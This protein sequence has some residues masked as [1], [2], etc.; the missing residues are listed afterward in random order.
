MP[1][2]GIAKSGVKSAPMRRIVVHIALMAGAALMLA[3]CG[4]AD[5]RSPVP[6]FMRAKAPEPPPLEAPP[7][8]KRML[9]EKLDSV[10]TQASQPTHV[11]VSE[12]RHNLRGPGWTACVKAEVTSVTGKPLGT[13]TYRIEISDGVI[14]DRRQVETDDTCFI[15]S[16][17]PI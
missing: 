1:C 15:E 11:R 7:D 9:K 17:E 3:G 10:F 8:V 16:Y 6:E 5:V 2:S 12:P 14:S 4:F 13:Q